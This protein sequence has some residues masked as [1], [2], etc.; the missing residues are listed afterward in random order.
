MAWLP[1]IAPS[2]LGFYN[3]DKFPEW[4]GNLFVTSAR[5]GEI[6]NTG[7]IERV[8]F[9]DKLQEMRRETLFADLRQRF[10]DITE[11]PDGLLYATIERGTNALLRI[12]PVPPPE[13]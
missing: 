12:E 10:R 2:G 6:N 11:G 8:V 5:R 1:S 7:G 9:N 3:G 13:Q 4:K